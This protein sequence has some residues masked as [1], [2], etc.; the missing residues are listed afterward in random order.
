MSAEQSDQWAVVELMGH[1][2]LA[3]RIS[4]EERF[5][6]KLG[7]IDI[8]ID[9][10]CTGVSSGWCPKCGDCKCVEGSDSFHN[11]PNCPLHAPGS[12]HGEVQEGDFVTQY[13]SGQSV[14]RITPCTEEVARAV[15]KRCQPEPAYAWDVRRQLGVT[16]PT[17]QTVVESDEDEGNDTF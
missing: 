9:A 12:Q 4:E 14:Y 16:A 17:S 13:F 10:G 1:V 5:G 3:G 15:A 6:S 8:P 11:D 7:R 2:R